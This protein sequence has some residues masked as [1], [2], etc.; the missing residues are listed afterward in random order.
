MNQMAQRLADRMTC[1]HGVNHPLLTVV[2]LLAGAV[3]GFQFA[4]CAM[5]VVEAW[6]STRREW[7]RLVTWRKERLERQINSRS[8][9]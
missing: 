2:L 6:F 3:M 4:V 9:E 1:E 8:S 7:Q 5:Q